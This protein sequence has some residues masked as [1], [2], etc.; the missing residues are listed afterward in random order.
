MCDAKNSVAPFEQ[1][2]P[3]SGVDAVHW[4]AVTV[5]TAVWYC[6]FRTLR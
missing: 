2:V 4:S 5:S 1:V 3:T 6:V